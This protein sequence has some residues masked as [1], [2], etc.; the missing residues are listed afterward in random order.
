[1]PKDLDERWHSC[2]QCGLELDRDQNSALDIKRLGL[3]LLARTSGTD[4]ALR[5]RAPEKPLALAVGSRHSHLLLA[6]TPFVALPGSWPTGS[7]C[8]TRGPQ[9]EVRYRWHSVGVN[10]YGHGRR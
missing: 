4:G 7:V 6:I 3:L 10:R 2:P 8:P 9:Q 5:G 1:M